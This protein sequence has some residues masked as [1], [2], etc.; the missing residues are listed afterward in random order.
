MPGFGR[1]LRS[2]YHF[3][4]LPSDIPLYH[5]YIPIFA[6]VKAPVTLPVKSHSTWL[7]WHLTKLLVKSLIHGWYI[8]YIYPKHTQ[9]N[10]GFTRFTAAKIMKQLRATGAAVL[11][12][13]T[14]LECHGLLKAHREPSPKETKKGWIGTIILHCRTCILKFILHCNWSSRYFFTAVEVHTTLPQMHIYIYTYA[15]MCTSL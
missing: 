5:H 2:L 8:W 11:L 13:D 12:D 1:R 10:G 3:Y 14:R 9:K 4:N 6:A 15:Y 7:T